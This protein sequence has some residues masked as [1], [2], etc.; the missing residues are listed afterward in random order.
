ML[1]GMGLGRSMP[2]RGMGEFPLRPHQSSFIAYRYDD[3]TAL[4][5]IITSQEQL[6]QPVIVTHQE[7]VSLPVLITYP[8]KRKLP[9]HVVVAPKD[10]TP[11]NVLVTS[12]KNQ[13][14]LPGI[15]LCSNGDG[16]PFCINTVII[17][18]RDQLPQAVAHWK[19]GSLPVIIACHGQQPPHAHVQDKYLDVYLIDQ[20]QLSLPVHARYQ[21]LAPDASD[22][23]PSDW[24]R[25]SFH[26]MVDAPDPACRYMRICG[27]AAKVLHGDR[28]PSKIFPHRD[29]TAW[30]CSASGSF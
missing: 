29:L 3:G 6:P 17:T 30:S 19:Q 9:V 5:P 11:L 7:E 14:P 13:P 27:M 25:N 15:I 24:Y 1:G 26:P 2:L 12:D 21:F 10:Q 22:Q 18:R 23:L 16:L 8:D 4:M 28:E 20:D